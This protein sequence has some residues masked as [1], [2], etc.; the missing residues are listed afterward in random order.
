MIQNHNI[1]YEKGEV[2]YFLRINKF[3]DLT[4]EEYETT[5]SSYKKPNIEYE[6]TFELNKNAVVPD[7]IDW[8]QKGAVLSVQDQGYCGSC[9]AFSAVSIVFIP[10]KDDKNFA[11]K[12]EII[13]S[14]SFNLVG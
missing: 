12:L 10:R 7:S 6:N 11:Y 13:D 2:S 3:A 1:R 8:K 5:Y 14:I 9:Y 4:D